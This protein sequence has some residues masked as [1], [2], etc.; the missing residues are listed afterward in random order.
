M[1]A[2]ILAVFTSIPV[3][4][5]PVILMPTVQAQECGNW[6]NEHIYAEDLGGGV[7]E[8]TY[9]VAPQVFWNNETDSWESLLFENH[10]DASN[11]AIKKALIL[12]TS[13]SGTSP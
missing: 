3:I 4:S 2:L 7:Y 10:T 1:A 11:M 12:R 8:T 13:F 5:M 6:V 9:Y